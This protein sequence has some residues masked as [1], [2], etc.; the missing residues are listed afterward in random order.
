MKESLEAV[1]LSPNT[2]SARENLT[3]G[4][5]ALGRFDEAEQAAREL[6]RI[7]PDSTGA[8]FS[9][10]VFGF[11]RR[12]QA[13][14]DREVQWAKGKREEPQMV[15]YLAATA[16]YFGKLKQSE[17]LHKRAVEMFKNQNRHENASAE[18]LN[19]AGNLVLLGKCQQAKDNAKAAMALFR[20]QFGLATAAMIYACL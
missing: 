5:I 14:M 1:R 4:F 6:Q 3:S 16:M 9:N 17:E 2:S 19:L 20:G 7:N 11:F 8:H 15:S 18:L 12:D 13:T 10:Y